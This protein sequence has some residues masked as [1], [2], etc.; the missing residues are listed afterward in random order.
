MAIGA[1]KVNGDTAGVEN[2]D[3]G[4]YFANAK[5]INTGISS[6]IQAF[7]I[8][9]VAGNLAAELGRGT[10]GTPG[11]VETILNHI[12]S[13]ATVIAYQVDAGATAANTQLSVIVE[14]SSW[15]NA[16]ALQTSLRASLA[17]NVGAKT[18]VTTT[19]LDVRNVGIKL[20]AS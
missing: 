12:A 5:I 15:T 11:G 7:N 6:P 18:P 17:S 9:I 10:D 13:N 1:T 2:V 16:L 3:N 19:T 8:Q 4:R 20:A 14:R